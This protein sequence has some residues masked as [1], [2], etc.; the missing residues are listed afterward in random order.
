MLE[1]ITDNIYLT[2]WPQVDSV[3]FFIHFKSGLFFKPHVNATL[4]ITNCY[5]CERKMIT[6]RNFET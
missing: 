2:F 4:F 5:E 3:A 6:I 1:I